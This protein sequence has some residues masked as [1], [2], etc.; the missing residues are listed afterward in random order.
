MGTDISMGRQVLFS[1]SVTTM[2]GLFALI[3]LS[4]WTGMSQ[5]IVTALFWVTQSM[6]HVRNIYLALWCHSAGI[7]PIGGMLLPYYVFVR[8]LFWH[9]QDILR[10]G[11]PLFPSV[12]CKFHTLLLLLLLLFDLWQLKVP[13]YLVI[14][15]LITI[16][17]I[18]FYFGILT[19]F[20]S[21]QER[22]K[23]QS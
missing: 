13:I 9:V 19:Y 14:I 17:Q 10:R 21:Y 16:R 22:I 23:G 12:S 3:T 1:L 18:N 2:S 8:T 7:L 11:G 4:D 5:S 6:A 15:W 20:A